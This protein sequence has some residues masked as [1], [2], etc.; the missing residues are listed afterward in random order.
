MY[1]IAAQ[2]TGALRRVCFASAR[3]DAGTVVV[4]GVFGVKTG[5]RDGIGNWGA[6]AGSMVPPAWHHGNFCGRDAVAFAYAVYPWGTV[7]CL[8]QP[9]GTS[10]YR[11]RHVPTKTVGAA[12]ALVVRRSYRRL[13]PTRRPESLRFRTPSNSM[14]ACSSVGLER[15]ATNRGVGGSSPSWPKLDVD[16]QR[17]AL[18]TLTRPLPH[19]Y[20][21]SYVPMPTGGCNN[22]RHNHHAKAAFNDQPAPPLSFL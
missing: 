2:R 17:H 15:T 20:E 19:R 14:R 13:S 18:Q 12:G 22:Q 5:H 1:G 16:S 4:I 9:Q 6:F 21:G 11:W 7:G 10:G 8:W 3:A